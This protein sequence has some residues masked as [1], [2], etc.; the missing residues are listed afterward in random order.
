[1]IMLKRCLC[2]GALVGCSFVGLVLCIMLNGT[3]TRSDDVNAQ[4][5]G[6]D[7]ADLSAGNDDVIGTDVVTA[8]DYERK[9]IRRKRYVAF[10]VGSSFSVST[11]LERFWWI[12]SFLQHNHHSRTECV[13]K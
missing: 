7:A 12:G 8:T 1:M 3:A 5:N 13:V 9:L 6:N 4:H 11:G 10:P 2:L